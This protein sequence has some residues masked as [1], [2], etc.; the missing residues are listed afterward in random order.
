M[1]RHQFCL[2]R[3]LYGLST[4][5]LCLAAMI[6]R[7][8]DAV[9]LPQFWAEDGAIFY[10]PAFDGRNGEAFLTPWAGYLHLF[11]RLVAWGTSLAPPEWAPALFNAAALLL[12]SASVW[13]FTLSLAR[14]LIGCDHLRLAIALLFIFS[15]PAVETYGNLTNAHW[16]MC[17]GALTLLAV[18]LEGSLVALACGFVA[19]TALSSPLPVLFVPIALVT[20]TV[21]SRRYRAAALGL[22]VGVVLQLAG[23]FWLSGHEPEIPEAQG[24]VK[25]LDLTG[26]AWHATVLHLWP[27]Y[28][29]ASGFHAQSASAGWL[30]AG[31][32]FA[33]LLTGALQ[34]LS[35]R[36][37]C[38][39]GG[40][41]YLLVSALVMVAVTR[42]CCPSR[43]LLDQAMPRGGRYIFLPYAMCV[44]LLG[45]ALQ[46]EIRATT[47][48]P[49]I[50][51]WILL[52]AISFC[53]I[54]GVP[55]MIR[56]D[57]LHWCE[58]VREAR[59]RGTATIP[60][61]P[62]RPEWEVRLTM[63]RR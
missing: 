12:A 44:F 38:M 16:W 56:F 53:S 3:F 10:Q 21:G 35:R 46:P 5:A 29:A 30:L 20:L 24:I 58:H 26:D 8:P 25:I 13:L 61:N 59:E 37:I 45:L 57:D 43:F 51:A 23:R 27:G 31:L 60:I 48:R 55:P 34:P 14:P 50:A 22:L 42:G 40:A 54:A 4:F 28:A 15:N 63:S 39:V 47:V 17:L 2:G 41:V 52:A 62:V 19:L 1:P 32:L 9:T 49:R 36:Q 7:R 11:P 33:L 18:P 6:A